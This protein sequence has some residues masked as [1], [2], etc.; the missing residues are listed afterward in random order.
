[1]SQTDRHGFRLDNQDWQEL[2]KIAKKSGFDS[3]NKLIQ[4]LVKNHLTG[5]E[6]STEL[7]IEQQSEIAKL[8]LCKTKN[9][10]A[11]QDVRIKTSYA[12]YVEKYVETFG[13]FP[14]NSG[15]RALNKK[16][17]NENVIKVTET[18]PYDKDAI[19][20]P[21]CKWWTNSK[22]SIQFQINRI[23]DHVR[24]IHH[25]SFTESEAKIISELLV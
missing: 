9:D 19:Y 8:E 23:T 14:S 3:R 25:R 15:L 18:Q 20:C 2:E 1:M 16:S 7:T 13:T 24:I 11:K 21:D 17:K 6:E 22:D 10:I 4:H 5:T 12:N